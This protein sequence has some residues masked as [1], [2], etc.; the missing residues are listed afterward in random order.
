MHR[1]F[2]FHFSFIILFLAVAANAGETLNYGI[3]QQYIAPRAMGMGNT[4]SGIDDYNVM[5]YNPAGLAYLKEGRMNVGIGGGV[6]KDFVDFGKDVSD[7]ADSDATDSD[8]IDQASDLLEASYGNTY[9][10]RVPRMSFIYARPKWGIALI[11]VDLSITLMPHQL[12]GPAL[13]VTAYQDST[14]AFGFGKATRSKKF[15]WGFLGKAIYRANIDKSLLAIDLAGDGDIIRDQDFKE[16]MTVDADAGVMWSPFLNRKKGFFSKVK[17]TFSAVVR[18]IADYGFTSNFKLYNKDAED[19]SE[20]EK[21]HRRI[22]LGSKWEL[23]SFSVFESQ[24]MIDVRDILH[25][26]WTFEKGL[27]LGAEL[28]YNVGKGLYGSLQGGLNQMYWTAGVGIQSYFFKIDLTSYAE[29]YG[30]KSAK[31]S[32]R[33]YMAQVNFNF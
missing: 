5:F 19:T 7:I 29:E 10:A 11:P 31:K 6:S 32:D 21:L 14:L 17:P 22:D 12:T 27:H 25:E 28:K 30:T 18:N 9:A 20:P 16:G 1:F 13:D 23:P 8:K 33:I 4:F 26:Y 24:V 2:L 3:H 15:A